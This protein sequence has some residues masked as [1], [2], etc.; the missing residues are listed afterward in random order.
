VLPPLVCTVRGCHRRLERRDRALRCENGH[1]FDVAREGY[2][3]LLQPQDRRSRGPGD[4][5]EAIDARAALLAAGIGS[6]NLDA[7]VAAA[8]TAPLS[9]TPPVVID[10]GSGSGE[11]LAR[12]AAV[13]QICGVGIDLSTAAAT[14]AARRVPS[15]TW[16]VANADRRLPLSDASVSLVL[17]IHG[18]RNPEECRRVLGADGLLIVA[19]PAPDDLAELRGEVQGQPVERERVAAVVAEHAPGF[20]VIEERRVAERHTLGRAALLNLLRGTY[21]G[22]RASQSARIAD[23]DSLDVTVASDVVVFARRPVHHQIGNH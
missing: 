6:T 21:R 22:A 16:V 10:L 15:V 1:T 12:L 13:R 5:R 20:E 8:A 3:N 19:V 18:R 7:I 4:S 9:G 17:S 14:H 23:L 2:V 11:T